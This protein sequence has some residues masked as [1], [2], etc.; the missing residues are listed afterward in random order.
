M[1]RDALGLHIL[2]GSGRDA[3]RLAGVLTFVETEA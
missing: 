1:A 3:I 2:R